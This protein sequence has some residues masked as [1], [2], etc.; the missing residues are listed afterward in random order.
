[1][2]PTGWRAAARRLAERIWFRLAVFTAVAIALALV[3]GV[4]GRVWPSALEVDL[5]QDSVTSILQ[6]IAT[7]MLAVTTFS[8]T[9]MLT[10]YT[11]ASAGTTPRA[12]QLLVAD[13]TSQNA[14]S[15]FLGSFVFAIVGIVALSTG[16]YGESGRTVLFIGTLVVI[17]VI[18]VTLTR[19][20]QH[21]TGFGRMADVIDRVEAAATEAACAHARRP[22]LGGRPAVDVPASARTVR[23]ERAG[24]VTGVDM[25]ALQRVAGRHRLTVHL[26]VVPG[27]SIGR[28]TPIV[29]VEGMADDEVVSALR[30]AVRVEAHRTYEQD[31]RLGFVA[32]GEIG[33]RALSPATNDPGS[34]IEALGAIERVLTALLTTDPDDAIE[35][36]DVHVPSLDLADAIEDA[37]RPIARD[38]AAVI[39][40]GLRIQ[41][42]VRHLTGLA[43]PETAAVL[44]A[45][46]RRA[47][48]RGLDALVDVGDRAL[49]EAA[50]REARATEPGSLQ[51]P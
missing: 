41:R 39:E 20:I 2:Q 6:I 11:T 45:A 19:W 15:T 16:Y 43:S 22:H 35:H 26:V 48:T 27:T 34:A 51:R 23:S 7:S 4:A 50:A 42:V 49:L 12:I 8:L 18:V 14:L 9:A 30:G 25:A 13:P 32:L 29:E 17:A 40:V 38:G 5:G 24:I 28:G 3:A 31:P 36:P 33:S 44:H 10:S 47:E 37:V 21:L 1:M 46:S